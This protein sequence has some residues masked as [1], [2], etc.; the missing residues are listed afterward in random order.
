M[1]LKLIFTTEPNGRLKM[2]VGLQ[3][4]IIDAITKLQYTAPITSDVLVT[5]VTSPKFKDGMM[6]L[7]W[8]LLRRVSV[9]NNCCFIA[10][11]YEAGC[12]DSHI[13]SFLSHILN[14]KE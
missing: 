8:N 14:Y 1:I 10:E 9:D 2:P 11:A 12:N 3:Q 4:D 13:D 7:R 6:A 5:Y